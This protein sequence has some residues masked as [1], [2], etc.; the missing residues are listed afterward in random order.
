MDKIKFFQGLEYGVTVLI[1][2]I[3]S[4]SILPLLLSGGAQASVTVPAESSLVLIVFMLTYGIIGI[5]ILCRW[6]KFLKSL[7]GGIVIL[8]VLAVACLSYSWSDSP[9]VTLKRLVALF[10]TSLVGLY[11]SS[12][13]TIRQQLKLLA[14]S[15]GLVVLG[16]FVFAL[17]L[18]DYGVMSVEHVGAWRGVFTHKNPLGIRMVFSAV[19]FFL[20]A[21]GEQ[22]R[23][24][25]YFL[26]FFASATLVLLAQSGTALVTLT[27]VLLALPVY[28]IFVFRRPLKIIW[29]LLAVAFTNPEGSLVAQLTGIG[30]IFAWV[31]GP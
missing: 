25:L 15:F 19:I 2:F 16:S 7:R 13:Y 12:R 23:R 3:Y 18:P 6:K 31:F 11:L 8:P 20:L 1:L 10:G 17:A 26:G 22:R 24:W 30:V 4:C 9:D 27:L 21:I 5:L 14:C 29:G 28:R